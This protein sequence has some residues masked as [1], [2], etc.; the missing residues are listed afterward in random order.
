MAVAGQ[1]RRG[2]DLCLLN[3]LCGCRVLIA[4]VEELAEHGCLVLTRFI[5]LGAL[6]V[7]RACIYQIPG[8]YLQE[9]LLV[10]A[11]VFA[12]EW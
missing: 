4:L 6:A 2:N 11:V 8:S 7:E 1:A 5:P 10:R 3:L 9:L 12:K